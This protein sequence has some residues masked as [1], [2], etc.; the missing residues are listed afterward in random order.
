MV[1]YST[2]LGTGLP[3]EHALQGFFAAVMCMILTK[4]DKDTTIF[5]E[6]L[7]NFSGVII[8]KNKFN[9]GQDTIS[10]AFLQYYNW[11]YFFI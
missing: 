9:N 2:L 11:K 10:A 3:P 6:K 7:K 1:E 5:R 4:C 8:E